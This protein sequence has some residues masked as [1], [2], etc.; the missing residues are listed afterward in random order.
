MN[1]AMLACLHMQKCRKTGSVK[2]GNNGCKQMVFAIYDE[3][4]HLELSGRGIVGMM[5][6]L[7]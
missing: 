3:K 6:I 7:P 4:R 5:A 2:Q 1:Q